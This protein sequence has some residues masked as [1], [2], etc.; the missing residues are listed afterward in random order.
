MPIGEAWER[1]IFKIDRASIACYFAVA[2]WSV[3]VQ[4]FRPRVLD[5]LRKAE[6]SSPSWTAAAARE[7]RLGKLFTAATSVIGSLSVAALFAGSHWSKRVKAGILSCQ[8]LLISLPC[9]REFALSPGGARIQML[10][11]RYLIMSL[12]TAGVGALFFASEFPEAYCR[13]LGLRKG[14]F[15]LFSSHAFMH[16]SVA[17]ASFVGF[18]GQRLWEGLQAQARHK[19][20]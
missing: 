9:L 4:H 7:R 18:R 13:A 10:V 17:L 14:S 2:T 5:A 6:V 16:C 20:F 11:L 1:I 8:L 12:S 15:D 3:G 19:G